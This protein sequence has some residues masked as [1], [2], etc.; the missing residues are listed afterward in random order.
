MLKRIKGYPNLGLVILAYIAFIALG[1]PDGLM[2]IAWPSIRAGFSI[3]LDALGMLITLGTAGYTTSSFLSGSFISRWGIGRLLTFSCI[4]TGTALL[5]YT[6][7]PEWWMMVALGLLVGVGAGAIDAGL[8][9]YVAANFNEGLMQ[10]LHACYGIGVAMGPII[11]TVAITSYYSWQLGYR[12]VAGTQLLLA[13]C[14]ALTIPMWRNKQNSS[15][16]KPLQITDYKTPIILTLRQSRVWISVL[17]FFLYVGAEI[18]VG[19]WTYSLLVEARHIDVGQAGFFAGSFWAM[20]TIGRIVA[21]FFAKRIGNHLLVQGGLS[22]AIL[23]TLLLIWNPFEAANLLAVA[24]IGF[25]IAPIFP[26]LMSGTS[27]RVNAKFAANTIGLQIAASGLG[28]ALIPS[29]LGILARRLSLEIIPIGFLIGFL[30]L[31]GVYQISLLMNKRM[32]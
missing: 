28:S 6:L 2:G 12:M 29:L 27:E 32:R 10:W 25:A 7:V 20:F 8:N 21:G 13:A 18:S 19:L 1:M 3:P 26:A 14:F 16:S 5:G 4:L 17:L 11:M 23:G 22:F 30:G 9:S 31:F 24:L 15:E